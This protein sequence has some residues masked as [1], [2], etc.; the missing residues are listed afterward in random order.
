MPTPA[1]TVDEVLDVYVRWGDRRHKQQVTQLAHALQTAAHAA[2]AGA[3]PTLVVAALLHDVGTVLM[4]GLG[5]RGRHEHNGPAFLADVFPPSVLDPIALHVAA[6]AYIFG[7]MS[8]EA[9]ATLQTSPGWDDAVAL[10]YW[11]EA[12]KVEGAVVPGLSTYEPVLRAV[13]LKRT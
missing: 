13:A 9:L 3:A 5:V 6:E 4:L 12:G 10:R 1:A 7:T 2:E 8:A 11:D